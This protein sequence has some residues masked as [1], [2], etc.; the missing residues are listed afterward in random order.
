MRTN[1]YKKV[2]TSG[3]IGGMCKC[4]HEI[5]TMLNSTHFGH[6]NAR[7]VDC[8]VEPVEVW[9]VAFTHI[10]PLAGETKADHLTYEE[11]VALAETP[12]DNGDGKCSGCGQKLATE[13]DFA[14]HF[15]IK[16]RRHLNLGDCPVEKALSPIGN[17]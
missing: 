4:G 17:I 10:A 3:R 1:I 8:P 11:A 16:D 7:G 5:I 13:L 2:Y 9:P 12:F 6:V 15:T 14:A